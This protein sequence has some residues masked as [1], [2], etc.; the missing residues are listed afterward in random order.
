M[1]NLANFLVIYCIASIVTTTLVLAIPPLRR[2]YFRLFARLYAEAIET[3]APILE[4]IFK[5]LE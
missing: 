4:S 3:M 1:S 2:G 5:I